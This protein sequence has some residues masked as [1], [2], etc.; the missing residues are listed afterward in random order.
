M[1]ADANIGEVRHT[2]C[3]KRVTVTKTFIDGNFRSPGIVNAGF[4]QCK[5]YTGSGKLAHV[6]EVNGVK[7]PVV[8]NLA[9]P[10]GPPILPWPGQPEI[11]PSP[12]QPPP[13]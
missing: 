2:P 10:N 6:A 9:I 13:F 11:K 3:G 12:P 1:L 7:V 8:A 5:G 4:T